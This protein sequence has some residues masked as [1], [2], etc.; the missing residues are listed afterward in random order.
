[1]DTLTESSAVLAPKRRVNPETLMT[2]SLNQIV[3][4]FPER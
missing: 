2:D 3:L 4:E 1:M